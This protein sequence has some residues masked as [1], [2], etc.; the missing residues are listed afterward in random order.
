MDPRSVSVCRLA[1][2]PLTS[3]HNFFRGAPAAT[4]TRLASPGR[5]GRSRLDRR[6]AGLGWDPAHAWPRELLVNSPAVRRGRA[7]P[8]SQAGRRSTNRSSIRAPP[9]A[10][11]RPPEAI[12]TAAA[13]APREGRAGAAATPPKWW[14][15]WCH[16]RSRIRGHGS[17]ARGWFLARRAGR[18]S[19]G[20]LPA[21]GR[22]PLPLGGGSA[23]GRRGSGSGLRA[24]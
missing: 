17:R 4:A 18:Q 1:F 23:R 21:R 9:A 8:A 16:G 12:G 5:R 22:V 10:R 14:W 15:W 3:K 20:P 19:P 13:A 2:S 6:Q 7:D 11:A 24:R